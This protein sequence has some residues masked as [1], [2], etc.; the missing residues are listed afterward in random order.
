MIEWICKPFELLTADELY[1]ILKLRSEVFVVEQ[2][3]IYM[4]ADDKDQKCYHLCGWEQNELAAYARIMPPGLSYEEASIGRVVTNPLFR[5]Q[6]AGKELMNKAITMTLQQF[7]TTR[8]RIGA[9]LY[10]LK[11]YTDLGFSASGKVYLEDGI[12]H[13]EMVYQ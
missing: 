5:K 10:L 9:Q 6:G 4:D 11:F 7:D 3:C 12:E 2:Q 8:I 13:I 1:A